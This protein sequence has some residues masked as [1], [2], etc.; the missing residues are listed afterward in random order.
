[1]RDK[2]I[3]FVL[4]MLIL[5]IILNIISLS[6]IISINKQNNDLS[7][8]IHELGLSINFLQQDIQKSQ[9]SEGKK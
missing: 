3:L 4:I 5:S 6:I 2:K 1:M 9:N 7:S 8:Q